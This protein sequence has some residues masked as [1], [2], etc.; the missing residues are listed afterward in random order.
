MGWGGGGSELG[1]ETVYC[2]RFEKHG[3]FSNFEVSLG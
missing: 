2:E 3:Y 1:S